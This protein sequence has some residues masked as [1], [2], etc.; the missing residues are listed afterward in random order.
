MRLVVVNTNPHASTRAGT[1]ALVSA[2]RRRLGPADTVVERH[3]ARFDAAW[4]ASHA[5]GVILGPQG[6]PFEAYGP[7]AREHLFCTLRGLTV[8][9]LAICGGHQALVLAHG[10]TIAPVSGQPLGGSYAGLEKQVGPKAVQIHVAGDP[11]VS[12]LPPTACLVASHVEAV[13]VLPDAFELVLIGAPGT[14]CRVQGVRLRGLPVWGLQGHPERG[15]DGGVLLD[16]F[17]ALVQSS[18]SSI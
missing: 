11:L 10:G 4:L 1:R 18:R 2:F 13:S 5:D 14:P 3:F 7:A 8:P 9:T 17:V 6:T 16:R 12:A 15:A